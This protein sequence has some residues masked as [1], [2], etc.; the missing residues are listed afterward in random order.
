MKR[1][2][3]LLLLCANAFAQGLAQKS[4]VHVLY[5]GWGSPRLGALTPEN[6]AQYEEA[7]PFDGLLFSAQVKCIKPQK[8]IY[9]IFFDRF[10]LAPADCFF[11]DDLQRN[12]DAARACGMEGWTFRSGD[13]GELKK[14]LEL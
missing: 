4:D 11:I 12:I 5:I 3:S 2:L 6:V 13:V 8:E 10:G 14:V 9:Q 7:A 1:L